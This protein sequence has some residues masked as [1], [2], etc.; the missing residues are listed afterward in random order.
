MGPSR[1]MVSRKQH[2]PLAAKTPTTTPQPAVKKEE[3]YAE[4]NLSYNNYK[5]TGKAWIQR[6]EDGKRTTFVD[7]H[8]SDR[9]GYK[10]S[11]VYRLKPG[12]YLVNDEGTK[13]YDDRREIV[14]HDDGKIE[15][16]KK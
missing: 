14:V 15:I 8:R 9:D 11:K 13:S 5:G 7:A 12:R 10:G 2:A 16:V 6:I 3:S 4:Y 1:I